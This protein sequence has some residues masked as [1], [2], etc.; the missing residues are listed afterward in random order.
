[1]KP[2]LRIMNSFVKPVDLLTEPETG[3]VA[4]RL[5]EIVDTLPMIGI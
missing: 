1:M 5:E 3:K 4:V 2:M